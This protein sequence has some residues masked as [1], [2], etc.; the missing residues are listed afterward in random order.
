[1]RLFKTNEPEPS[2]ADAAAAERL[3]AI[4][5][6][7]KTERLTYS[8]FQSPPESSAAAAGDAAADH[9]TEGA[10]GAEPT[11]EDGAAEWTE[12]TAAIEPGE[13][14]AIEPGEDAAA[15]SA[16]GS[17]APGEWPSQD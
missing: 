11:E 12:D 15:D 2:A 3:Q 10:A 17:A 9:L 13:D 16:E 5:G 14:A 4:A 1:M 6:R 8:R 7:F